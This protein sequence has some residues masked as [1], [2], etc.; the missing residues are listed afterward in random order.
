MKKIFLFFLAT[1]CYITLIAQGVAINTDG[2]SPHPSAMLD[3]KSGTKGL[4]MPRTS[5]ASKL[6]IVNPPTGL[7]IYDSTIGSFWFRNAGFWIE[8]GRI[9]PINSNSFFGYQSGRSQPTGD[10]N[11]GFGTE[12]LYANTTGIGNTSIGNGTLH[13]NT[14]GNY[15]TA[16]GV[17]A[18]YF[19]TS[20][21]SNTAIGNSALL[22]NQTGYSNVAVG[23]GALSHNTVGTN[24]VAIGDSALLFNEGSY[25]IAIGDQ[26][27]IF[28]SLGTKNT[29]LGSWAARSNQQGVSNV[30]I[31][32]QSM[33]SNT[34][35]S[36]VAVGAFADVQGNINTALGMSTVVNGNLRYATAIG[37]FASVGCSNCL[38]LGGSDVLRHTKVGINTPNPGTDLDIVQQTDANLN[39]TRGIRLRRPTGGGQWR[40]FL[41]P[42]N[43]YVFQFNNNLYSYIE[44]VS[45]NY[46]SSSDER[47]KTNINSLPGIMDKLMLLQPK[48]YQYTASMDPDR[49]S[50]GFLAQEVEKLFPDFVFTSENGI[51]GIAYSNFSVIAIKAIQEQQEQ[52]N[53]LQKKNDEHEEREEQFQ[54]QIKILLER[55][56]ALEKKSQ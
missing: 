11:S 29:A 33:M 23:S 3:I 52:I 32:F 47:L 36:N 22:L 14:V 27:L 30:A 26:A 25:N 41:D 48:T 7:T 34:G 38:V 15:N 44:P 39:N 6:S 55:V 56:A 21:Y 43:N 19:N 16:N 37:A 8:S 54:N 10:F 18:L 28:N 45:A 13:S 31:G 5:T 35:D 42:S 4:L 49:N 20:G 12:A 17:S 50:W 1:S 9:D 2:S 40:V 51:K 53:K 46:V 24:S